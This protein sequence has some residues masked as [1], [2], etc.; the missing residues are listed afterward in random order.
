MVEHR[1]DDPDLDAIF[2]ALAHPTRRA[3]LEAVAERPQRIGSIAEP[4]DVSLAAISKHV[5]VLEDAGLV[6]IE[7]DGRIRRCHL[8]AAPLGQAFGWLTRYRVFWEDRFDALAI[9][10][11]RDDDT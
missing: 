9:H 8:N 1:R 3:I 5:G 10:L 2:Q 7:A 6:D 11:D 4:F